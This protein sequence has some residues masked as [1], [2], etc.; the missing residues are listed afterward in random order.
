[1][2]GHRLTNQLF[3]LVL[4]CCSLSS[5]ICHDANSVD[6]NLKP[7]LSATVKQISSTAPTSPPPAAMMGA[8]EETVPATPSGKLPQYQL[9]YLHRRVPDPTAIEDP[10]LRLLLALPDGPLLI[11]ATITIDGKPYLQLREKRVQQLLQFESNPNPEARNAALSVQAAAQAQAMVAEQRQRVAEETLK[12]EAAEGPDDTATDVAQSPSGTAV[13][14]AVAAY[15]EP[16]PVYD[17]IIRYMEA[18]EESPTADE[19]RW[20]LTDWVDGP[21]VLLLNDNYQRFRSDQKPAFEILDRDRDQTISAKELELAV[22]S[23]RECDLNGDDLVQYTELVEVAKDPRQQA[24]HAGHGKL[25]FLLPN[26]ATAEGIYQR[27]AHRYQNTPEDP[28]LL[29]RF[30]ANQDGQFDAAE[31]ED[32]KTRAADLKLS[33]AFHS[34]SPEKSKIEITGIAEELV[35]DVSSAIQHPDSITLKLGGQLVAFCAV[36]HGQSDQ[37]S[38]GAVDDGYPMLPIVDPNDDGRFTIRELRSLNDRLATFDTNQD[39]TL[40]QDEVRSTIRLC[41]GRGPVAHVELATIRRRGQTN[42][43]SIT[44]ATAGPDWFTRMDAN[45]DGDLTRKEFLGSDEHFSAAD[46]DAD[47][48]L[49]AAEAEAFESNSKQ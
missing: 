45:K 4:F 19:I 33:V 7:H 39:G 41:I 14:E 1:M 17:R 3:L 48:L 2:K 9:G 27:L 26:A 40:T 32:L 24:K 29:P 6:A 21:E 38:V 11:E 23:F 43:D 20:L 36:Q 15:L 28:V 37:I 10:R 25:T 31:I 18:T 34:A 22:S 49:S 16:S 5:A 47:T 46:A 13:A 35:G 42:A 8:V 30:D 44:P 12:A